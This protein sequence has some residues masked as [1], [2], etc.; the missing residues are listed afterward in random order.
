MRWYA[1]PVARN[2]PCAPWL[3]T[4]A[5]LLPNAR[6]LPEWITLARANN[7][8]ITTRQHEIDALQ[9]EIRRNRAG[10]YPRVDLV[11]SAVNAENES[12]STLDQETRQYSIGVQVNIPSTPG[13]GVDASVRRAAAELARA[14]ARLEDDLQSL[15]LDIERQFRTIESGRTRLAALD[16][17]VASSELA[18][19][20]AR[21]GQNAGVFSSA[22]V[23][24]ALRRHHPAR[25]DAAQARYELL[26]ARIRLQAL[27]GIAEED[28]IADVDPSADCGADAGQALKT[29][30]GVGKRA[31]GRRIEI[32]PGWRQG[33]AEAVRFELTRGVETP[34]GFQVLRRLLLTSFPLLF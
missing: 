16:D 1:S 31:Q 23:L 34:D 3:Q 17:A 20:G 18:L 24:D 26:I 10:H 28:I 27:A 32:R 13:G 9:H 19:Q 6:A 30:R 15:Q 12:I 7:P 21:R 14:Q 29:G 22:D 5:P 25:R 4:P 11:A 8:A 33:V 2:S